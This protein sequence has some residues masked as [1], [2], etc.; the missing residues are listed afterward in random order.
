M[1]FLCGCVAFLFFFNVP[2]TTEIYTNGHTRS[3]HDAL[4]SSSLL[5]PPVAHDDCSGHALALRETNLGGIGVPIL[6]RKGDPGGVHSKD[7]DQGD[8]DDIGEATRLVQ[9][10]RRPEWTSDPAGT[11][12]IVN[13]PAWRASTILYSSPEERRGGKECVQ[14]C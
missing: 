3:R 1:I 10:G 4:P 14:T 2:Q 9:T 5:L 11:G 13:P 7:K 12:A 8:K 6:R